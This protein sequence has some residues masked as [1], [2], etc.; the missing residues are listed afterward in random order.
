MT[1]CLVVGHCCRW[2]RGRGVTYS[3]ARVGKRVPF[4]DYDGMRGPFATRSGRQ[5]TD[6]DHAQQNHSEAWCILLPG[7][8]HTDRFRAREEEL[9]QPPNPRKQTESKERGSWFE[10]RFA[11]RWCELGSV[12]VALKTLALDAALLSVAAGR[13]RAAPDEGVFSASASLTRVVAT[14][15]PP[16]SFSPS[17]V[18]TVAGAMSAHD[19]A[20]LADAADLA[21]AVAF[22]QRALWMHKIASRHVESRSLLDGSP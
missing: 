22:L 3:T 12:A 5:G 13:G 17:F 2:L 21:A 8:P 6:H 9:G 7:A 16:I 14:L 15:A 11:I 20:G 10:Q 19:R 1:W 4:D 18:D